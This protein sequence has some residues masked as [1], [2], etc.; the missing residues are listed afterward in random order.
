MLYVKKKNG[1][2]RTCIDYRQLKKV[3]IKNKYPIPQI[4]DLFD[5]LQGESYFS[6][7]NLRSG[8]HQL[9]V[10]GEDLPKTSFQTRY[11]NYEFLVMSFGV[12]YSS[13]TF[14]DLMN[15]CSEIT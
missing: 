6:K 7:I 5:H 8:Y 9:W 1:S 4:G 2:L 13:T 15:R 14:M 10:I 12:S 11:G 3:T